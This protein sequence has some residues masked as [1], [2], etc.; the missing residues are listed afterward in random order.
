[1]FTVPVLHHQ[2]VVLWRIFKS[3]LLHGNDIH[4]SDVVESF[5]KNKPQEGSYQ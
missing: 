2:K 5:Q 3:A 4:F 1:V